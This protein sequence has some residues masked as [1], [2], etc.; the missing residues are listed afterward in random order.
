MHMQNSQFQAPPVSRTRMDPEGEAPT[1]K[2]PIK[3]QSGRGAT[4][5]VDD[6][7]DDDDDDDDDDEDYY[8]YYYYY[9]FCCIFFECILKDSLTARDSSVSSWIS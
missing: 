5:D 2:A 9:C 6:G 1:W 7:D 8:Y 4:D 3:D